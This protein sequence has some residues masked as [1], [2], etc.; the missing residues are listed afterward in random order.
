M[1]SAPK[2]LSE[3]TSKVNPKVSGNQ[4]TYSSIKEGIE[5]QR[6]NKLTLRKCSCRS[7]WCPICWERERKPA[8]E[9][10]KTFDWRFTRHLVVTC[11]PGRF[12]GE[13]ELA[14]TEIMFK[15]GRGYLIKNLERTEG[16]TIVDWI[17]FLE[18]HE[19]GF[20]HWHIF[21]EVTE[22]GKRG[23]IGR[24]KVKRH[25][26]FGLWI[27]EEY[28]K[29]EYHWKNI[30][31]DYFSKRGY[32]SDGGSHQGRLPEWAKDKSRMRRWEAKRERKR[33][34][35]LPQ[36]KTSRR[37]EGFSVGS[38]RGEWKIEKTYRIKLEECGAAC[39]LHIHGVS[40]DDEVKLK[41]PYA[42]MKKLFPWEYEEGK[43]LVME[44]AQSH[45]DEFYSKVE[46]LRVGLA[47]ITTANRKEGE[48]ARVP[49]IAFPYEQIPELST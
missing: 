13:G 34:A 11:D 49:A 20:P 31:G 43:G 15:R 33:S 7:A 21:I 16:I 1:Q 28:I 35:T 22:Q 9:R 45:M 26:P 17:S 12:N 39:V 27:N 19:N 46:S 2:S 18:W 36:D 47:S 6:S 32:F 25:W 40:Y 44:I 41:L 23:M 10:L 24:E 3:N 14:Y 4:T 8:I 37:D 5:W 29:S 30:T 42:E 38:P 48:A